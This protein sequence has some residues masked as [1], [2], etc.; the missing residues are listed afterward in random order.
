MLTVGGWYDAGGPVG[1]AAQVLAI[2]RSTRRPQHA[3]HGPWVH[4]GWARG[5]GDG[6]GNVTF[7]SK[8]ASIYREQIEFPFFE[9][10]LK[11]TRRPDAARGAAMFETGVN[12]WRELD[13]WPPE[14]AKPTT[15]YLAA[16][17][18]LACGRRRRRR[19]FDEYVSDPNR[20]V[21]YVGTIVAGG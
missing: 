16:G 5:T 14:D 8:T 4:G 21:P 3:R 12:Q 15:L 13:A 17:G 9:H 7:G 19:R 1:A 2:E 11:G 20:P 18:R 10:Y 6:L